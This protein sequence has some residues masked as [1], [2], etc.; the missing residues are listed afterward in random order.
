M[1]EQEFLQ[2]YGSEKVFFSYLDKL[3]AVY[4]N[5]ELGIE[6]SG[7]LDYRD[8]ICSEETVMGIFQLDSFEFKVN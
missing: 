1:T 6:C 4:R 7:I 2:K 5:D 8:S 3:R